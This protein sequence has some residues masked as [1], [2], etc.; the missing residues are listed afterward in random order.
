[1][2]SDYKGRSDSQ[3]HVEIEP[4]LGISL[5]LQPAPTLAQ[6]IKKNDQEHRQA[7]KSQFHSNGAAWLQRHVLG[8]KWPLGRVHRVVIE[9]VDREGNDQC[10]QQKVTGNDPAPVPALVIR[11]RHHRS[12]GSSMRAHFSATF[13]SVLTENRL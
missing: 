5:S 3:H 1:M 11:R 8:R 6:R 9:A 12:C 10:D 7:E 4:V 13:S 2:E